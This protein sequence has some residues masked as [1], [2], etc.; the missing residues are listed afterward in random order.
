MLDR[1]VP[2]VLGNAD[3]TPIPDSDILY[4]PYLSFG[5]VDIPRFSVQFDVLASRRDKI[6]ALMKLFEPA[7]DLANAHGIPITLL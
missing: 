3:F 1:R 2:P 6:S 4:L 7:M 5:R